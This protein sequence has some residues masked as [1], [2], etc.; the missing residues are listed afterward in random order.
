M[1]FASPNVGFENGVDYIEEHFHSLTRE[2][3]VQI[4]V[5]RKQKHIN[6]PNFPELKKKHLITW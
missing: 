2:D 5:D 1:T 6:H 3:S 4:Q